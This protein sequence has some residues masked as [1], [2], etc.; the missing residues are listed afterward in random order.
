MSAQLFTL[1]SIWSLLTPGQS[2]VRVELVPD[3]PGPYS[4]GEVVNV[5][6]WLHSSLPAGWG[7]PRLA[8]IQFDFSQ[9]SPD[10]SLAPTLFFD[11]SSIPNDI[12]YER[13]PELPVPWTLNPLA[14]VCPEL[15]L[16]FP[17][18][19]TLHIGNL[20]VQLPTTAG[21]YRLDTLNAVNKGPE[22][23]VAGAMLSPHLCCG[24]LTAF[25]GEITGGGFDFV[26][27]PPPIPTL[28]EATLLILAV[29]LGGAG[30]WIT[31]RK[32][33]CGAFGFAL[34][35]PINAPV[36]AGALFLLGICRGV[37]A[38]PTPIPSQEVVLNVD[39][40]L[41]SATQG[42]D[43]VVV[44]SHVVRVKGARWI[45]LHFGEVQLS[46][47]PS[48]GNA[49]FLRITAEE[50]GDAQVL[51]SS[52][53][54]RW[55]NTSAYFNGEAVEIEL[56]ARAGTGANR[57]V[58]AYAV[59]GIAGGP[60]ATAAICGPTDDRVPSSDPRA[61]RIMPAGCSGF[62]FNERS[63]CLLTAGHCAAAMIFYGEQSVAQFNVPDSD[64]DGAIN[65]PLAQDQYP[66][67]PSSIQYNW[68]GSSL[69]H[70]WCQFG[71]FN[72]TETGLTPL[73]A[74]G[75]SYKLAAIVPPADGS[76][77]QITGYGIDYDPPPPPPP[78]CEG[79][80]YY[81]MYNRTQ[82]THT[83]PYQE[84]VGTEVRYVID[85]QGG[86]S[87]SAV[88][89][90][91]SGLV[92][93]INS[94]GYCG[95][96]GE[97][98]SGTAIDHPGLQSALACPIGVC[99]DCNGNGI[100]DQCDLN[101]ASPC[102]GCDVPGCG[103]SSDCNSNG[104]PDECDIASGTNPD[105]NSNSVPDECETVCPAGSILGAGPASETRDARQPYPENNCHTS[106]RQGI[107]SP[108]AY[109]GGPE[110]IYV[111]IGV[112]GAEEESCCWSLCE[113]DV[114]PTDP[115][116]DALADNAI[117]SVTEVLPDSGIYEI[118]LDRP[119]SAGQWTTI[120]YL[121]DGSSVSYASLPADVNRDGT[122]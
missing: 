52:A 60:P 111:Y 92:Y 14:C 119:I 107:G 29:L 109:T 58:L 69:E 28:S 66:F 121:G 40:G 22:L 89:H 26:V 74:Q 37:L 97:T 23:G 34:G 86:T 11:Y 2:Q 120:T 99:A 47:S 112:S 63:N 38:Q 50:D 98:N 41:V 96:G 17:P 55:K 8:G 88:E 16:P 25:D 18:G 32:S 64:C 56:L 84:K 27:A 104:V 108:N 94:G 10:L 12:G 54:A 65:Q 73:K 19:G 93:A 6:V 51:D 70:D 35:G 85:I 21:V 1:F 122:A 49:S 45:R 33:R 81:N 71:V 46:G 115:G 44:F 20:G 76:T 15:F 87:G 116:C 39:S 91:A 110:P 82:Q 105:C 113:T 118:L 3:T 101:C 30:S 31:G 102:G 106:A 103:G 114:E 13:H 42:T 5:D 100:L 43:P 68:D 90:V 67:D 53:L 57:L 79:Q 7:D 59:A 78:E 24:L 61:A 72:N 80:G 9:T 62:L 83:G 36:V 95:H 4:G 77:L 48:A 117:Q 75:A